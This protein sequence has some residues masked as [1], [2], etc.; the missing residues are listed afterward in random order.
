MQ[1]SYPGVGRLVHVALNFSSVCN[2][3]LHASIFKC[4]WIR[5]GEY[6]LH[7][8]R[9]HAQKWQGATVKVQ[10]WLAI[11][12][13]IWCSNIFC[14]ISLVKR[15]IFMGCLQDSQFVDKMVPEILSD[16]FMPGFPHARCWGR[17]CC[18]HG[19]QVGYTIIH[20][21]KGQTDKKKIRKERG[22]HNLIH[23]P[24]VHQL[25]TCIRKIRVFIFL[26]WIFTEKPTAV[27]S[28]FIMK[29]SYLCAFM[30]LCIMAFG[31]KLDCWFWGCTPTPPFTPIEFPPEKRHYEIREIQSHCTE[32][33]IN[34][35]VRHVFYCCN[36]W[37][38]DLRFNLHSI[39]SSLVL[40]WSLLVSNIFVKGKTALQTNP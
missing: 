16:V 1:V 27:I 17:S 2:K 13:I 30:L 15:E 11:L 36:Y 6:G 35:Q 18:R 34:T 29:L 19:T 24:H 31:S 39:K 40:R 21:T 32:I 12:S 8:A 22:K 4:S 10:N 7:A 3:I 23:S 28:I 20:Q 33:P 26:N 9:T 5:G 25:L 14:I 38:L 37:H